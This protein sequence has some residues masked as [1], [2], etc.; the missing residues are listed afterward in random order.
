PGNPNH[1]SSFKEDSFSYL[2]CFDNAFYGSLDVRFYGTFPLAKFWPEIEKQ[3]VR[4][5]ADTI[6]ETIKQ[7][8]IWAWKSDNSHQLVPTERKVAG[9]APHDLGNPTEDPLVL[10]NQYNFQSVSDWKDLNS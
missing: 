3:E 2:E 4:E 8:Y 10:P 5:Y 7:N 6:P 1:P 9:S